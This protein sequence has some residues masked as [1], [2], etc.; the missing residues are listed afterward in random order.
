MRITNQ[1]MVSRFLRNLNANLELLADSNEK[2]S[3]GKRI[4]RPSDDPI[5]VARSLHLRTS[6]NETQQFIRNVAS[7]TSWMEAADSALSD[8]TAVL[9]RAK[10]IAVAG[11]NGTLVDGSLAALADEVDKL[12]EHLVQVANSDHAGRYIFGGFQTTA[13]P[14]TANR[15]P[16]PGGWIQPPGGQLIGSVTYNG[17]SGN[18]SYEV[19]SGIQA[20]VNAPG[21]TVFNQAFQALIDLRDNLRSRNQA[22]I[23]STSLSLIEQAVDNLLEWQAELGARTNQL[24]LTNTRLLELK[25]N[26]EKLLSENED[27]DIPEAI[28]R[29]KMQENVYRAALDSGARII[30]PTLLDFLR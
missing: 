7:A 25:A 6:I 16:A 30:Q 24:E 5:A 12:I 9:H 27:A 29:L 18:I 3:T 1:M 22:G 11:A 28:M 14:F 10:E 26:F 23:S 15:I 4:Q 8:A 21:D 2:L 19:G 13:P 20:T 17:D